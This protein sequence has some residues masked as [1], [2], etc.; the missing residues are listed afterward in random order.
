VKKKLHFWVILLLAF[1]LLLPLTVPAL[2]ET[3][4]SLNPDLRWLALYSGAYI[5]SHSYDGPPPF[6][7]VE[8]PDWWKGQETKAQALSEQEFN[9]FLRENLLS[10]ISRFDKGERICWNKDFV[11]TMVKEDFPDLYQKIES[12]INTQDKREYNYLP[13]DIAQLNYTPGSRTRTFDAIMYNVFGMPIWGFFCR[14]YWVWNSTSITSILPS[15]WGEAY[16]PL[17]TFDGIIGNQQNWIYQY[18]HWHKWVKGQFTL[19]AIPYVVPITH[20]YPWLDIYI[21]AGGNSYY[22]FGL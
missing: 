9:L 12:Q 13:T 6:G 5:V 19:W 21:S 8:S 17:W 15:S 16:A 4:S 3:K 18:W 1:L 10:A 2:G 7:E 22:S 14:I 11:Q 20:N